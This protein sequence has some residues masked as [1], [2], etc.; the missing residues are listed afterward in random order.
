MEPSS[1]DPR[2]SAALAQMAMLRQADVSDVSLDLYTAKLEDM[3]CD[4]SDIEVACERHSLAER[5]DGETAFP[6]MGQ[7]LKLIERVRRQRHDAEVAATAKPLA[8]PPP[9]PKD[10]AAVWLKR[11]KAS[12]KHG[13]SLETVKRMYPM[14]DEV[15]DVES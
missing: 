1:G 5:V 2:I 12:A 6:S 4:I 3:Q 11:V 7:L 14:P 15:P 10:R 9:I 13:F 8:L